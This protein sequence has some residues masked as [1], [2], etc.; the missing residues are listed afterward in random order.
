MEPKKIY[1]ILSAI[2]IAALVLGFI[3]PIFGI[4]NISYLGG[5]KVSVWVNA[6]GFISSTFPADRIR[7]IFRPL[8][9]LIGVLAVLGVIFLFSGT[10]THA[11]VGGSLILLSVVISFIV[12]NSSSA[13][14]YPLLTTSDIPS[15]S[16]RVTLYGLIYTLLVTG[17]IS[18]ITAIRDK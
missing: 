6:F 11:F 17:V 7:F 16:Q 9:Q 14:L 8:I 18:I 15:A 2:V 12:L 1:K 4:I 10:R 3:T 5:E 13:E